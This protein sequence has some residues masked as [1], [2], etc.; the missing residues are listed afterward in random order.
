MLLYFSLLVTEPFKLFLAP[1]LSY[2]NFCLDIIFVSS[3]YSD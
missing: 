2:P 3:N 1:S